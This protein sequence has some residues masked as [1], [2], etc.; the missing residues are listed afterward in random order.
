[1]SLNKPA[2]GRSAVS[3]GG[4]RRRTGTSGTAAF[5]LVGRGE[6]IVPPHAHHAH[7]DR[8]GHRRRGWHPR[9]ARRLADGQGRHRA[10]R[11]RP[12][13]RRRTA[14]STPCCSSIRSQPRAPGWPRRCAR[15]SRSCPEARL[16]GCV[17]ELRRFLEQPFES[18]E[19]G[20]LVQA[21]RARALRRRTA[22]PPARRARHARPRRDSHV[23][24]AADV[25]RRR[26]GHGVP[27]AQPLC[28]PV[29][30]AGR[31]AVPALHAVAQ[32][33]PRHARH[34]SRAARSSTAAHE[35]DFADAAHLTRT[36]YQMVGIAAVGVDAR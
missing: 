17:A 22:E 4:Q 10:P 23:G 31:P 16:A 15:T 25:D 28:P 6:G 18:M 35:A 11:R 32:A 33:D 12:L 2:A 20:E 13:L 26:R 5:S 21:L 9:R 3:R 19:F 1:M 8:V 14:R 7:S 29:Q 24:R 27:L 36:F 30:A 34:R